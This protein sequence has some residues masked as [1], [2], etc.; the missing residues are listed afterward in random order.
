MDWIFEYFPLGNK[1]K[2]SIDR[3]SW[4]AFVAKYLMNQIRHG[5]FLQDETQASLVAMIREI[6]FDNGEVK[7]ETNL[8][9]GENLSEL[10]GLWVWPFMFKRIVVK[11]A[12]GR[13]PLVA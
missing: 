12:H 2:L 8:N 9:E 1:C 10:T 6:V 3:E 4:N 11:V 5:D 13:L 7:E